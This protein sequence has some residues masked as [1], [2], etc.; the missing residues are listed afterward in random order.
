[1]PKINYFLQPN[2][3]LPK[4]LEAI[5]KRKFKK[6][7]LENL[8]RFGG[9]IQISITAPFVDRKKQNAKLEINDAFIQQLKSNPS[10]T[11]EILKHLTQ[12]QLIEVGKKIDFPVRTQATVREMR[13]SLISFFES[14]E[15]WKKI[16]GGESQTGEVPQTNL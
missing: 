10:N 1:M 6:N 8:S 9:R 11:G 14:K 3:E 16:T 5:I 15:M 4:E 2:E 13:N 12:N 7:V